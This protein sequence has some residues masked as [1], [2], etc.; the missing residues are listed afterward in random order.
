VKALEH[1]IGDC[2][3]CPLGSDWT[4]CELVG[5]LAEVELPLEDEVVERE[6][7]HVLP[8]LVLVL[9]LG[10]M[11]WHVAPIRGGC[12]LGD[13]DRHLRRSLPPLHLHVPVHVFVKAMPDSIDINR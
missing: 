4:H 3:S 11:K 5:E 9:V 7:G 2:G 8:A 12:R 13:R 10:W 6:P 1:G